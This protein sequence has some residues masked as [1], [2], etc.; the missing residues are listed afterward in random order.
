M[1][2]RNKDKQME[3][4][5]SNKTVVRIVVL[6]IGS[7]LFLEALKTA[8]H[9]LTLIFIAFFLTLALNAPVHWLSERLPG[10][11]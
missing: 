4:T 9:A 3:L 11:R 8:R 1:L 10:K 6:V 7:L 2:K 5:V